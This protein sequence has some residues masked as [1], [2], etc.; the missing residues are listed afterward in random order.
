MAEYIQQPMEYTCPRD[1][2][3]VTHTMCCHDGNCC[4]PTLVSMAPSNDWIIMVTA[5]LVICSC[6]V[7][8]VLAVVCCFWSK[9][10]LYNA[11]RANYS[12]SNVI[13]YSLGKEDPTPLMPAEDGKGGQYKPQPVKIKIMQDV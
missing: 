4:E 3:P 2:D 11:C 8:T 5:I 12:T 6:L 1:F 13:V 7:L 9:C 10:P